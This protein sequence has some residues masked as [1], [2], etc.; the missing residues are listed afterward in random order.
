[1][2]IMNHTA[3]REVSVVPFDPNWNDQFQLESKILKE[4]F[5]DLIIQIHHIGSTAIKGIYSK[6]ILDLMPEVEDINRV[7]GYDE[8]MIKKGYL[9]KGEFG[10]PER[11]FFIKG[12]EL[13][14]F[15]HIHMFEKGNPEI[16]RHLLFR[17]YLNHYSDVAKEYSELKIQLAKENRFDIFG[18]MDG[19][20][21]FI[22]EIDKKTKIWK[23]KQ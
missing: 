3:G 10:I 18:Y 15:L 14:H 1:M 19:K 11:R 13:N 16:E 2:I 21:A 22:K 20:D 9:P 7:D 8:K 6:P 5:G 23:Q 4:I 12:T 17:D